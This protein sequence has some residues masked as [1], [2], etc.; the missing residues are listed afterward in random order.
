MPA[1]R[2]SR[3]WPTVAALIVVVVTVLLGRWQLDRAHQREEQAARYD[4][5]AKQAPVA[6][7]GDLIDARVLD[8][9]RVSARGE[10]LTKYGIFL[11]NQVYQGQAGYHVYMPLRL[12]GSELCLVV[13]RG[14]VAAGRDRA[15]LPEIK[16]PGG[17]VEV[18]GTVQLPARFK[19]LG[20]TFREGRIWENVTQ[21]RFKAW[22]GLNL[23]PVMIRQTDDPG[24]G[25]VRDWPRPDSGADRNRGYAFQWFAFAA[26]AGFLWAYHFFRRVSPDVE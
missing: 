9:H 13:N 6:I 17:R 8:F 21:E 10:W 18:Y 22:S 20:S 11:D 5:L 25:L 2:A 4:S 24:D 15:H 14:W 3:F 23:Q 1:T 7:G 19:E 26:L 12:E 16:T